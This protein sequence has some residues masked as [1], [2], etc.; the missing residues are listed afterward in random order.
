MISLRPLPPEAVRG[1]KLSLVDAVGVMFSA[2]G[3]VDACRSFAQMATAMGGR[4]DS[5]LLYGGNEFRLLP[6]RGRTAPL[7]TQSISRTRMT[8]R[9]FIL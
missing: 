4:P 9:C 3:L 8:R 6:P 1:A 2:T 7:P 5:T